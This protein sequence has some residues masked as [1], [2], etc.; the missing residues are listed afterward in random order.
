MMK[1]HITYK[2]NTQ[3]IVNV[4]PEFY[5][6]YEIRDRGKTIVI[7][8]QEKMMDIASWHPNPYKIVLYEGTDVV[9]SH[10]NTVNAPFK[11]SDNW[12]NFMVK[13]PSRKE[14]KELSKIPFAKKWIPGSDGIPWSKG[15][16]MM[17][18]EQV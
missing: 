2:D 11:E 6:D 1:L 17:L 8:A 9:Y 10:T 14:R 4:I 16:I 7:T 18:N 15:I 3:R 12:H 13:G 5:S